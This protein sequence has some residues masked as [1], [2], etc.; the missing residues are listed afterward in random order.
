MK[1]TINLILTVL[2]VGLLIWGTAGM[3]LAAQGV[4]ISDYSSPMDTTQ[5]G[6][7]HDIP[8]NAYVGYPPDY[9]SAPNAHGW[10]NEGSQGALTVTGTITTIDFANRTLAL[11]DGEQFVLPV[12]LEYTNLPKVGDPVEVTFS[13][14]NGQ[15]MVRWI[16]RNDM[17]DSHGGS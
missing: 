11:D 14:Q 2:A 8:G 10:I 13:Q 5:P 1:S 9:S 7:T 17:A 12:S 16:D 4:Y 6:W 3:A 15:K